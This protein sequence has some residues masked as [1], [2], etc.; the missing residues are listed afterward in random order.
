MR[1][2]ARKHGWV[3]LAL[4]G[5]LVVLVGLLWRA[6][7]DVLSRTKVH[8]DGTPSSRHRA[9][10]PE[11]TG[12][13]VPTE[14]AGRLPDETPGAAVGESLSLDVP[15]LSP[16]MLAPNEQ[17]HAFSL[18]IDEY[19]KWLSVRTVTADIKV[20]TAFLDPQGAFSP[21]DDGTLT[22]KLK[23]EVIPL[24]KK[25]FDSRMKLRARVEVE[26]LGIVILTENAYDTSTPPLVWSRTGEQPTEDEAL[27][28]HRDVFPDGA[29]PWESMFRMVD[30]AYDGFREWE[31]T[32]IKTLNELE[33]SSWW[34]PVRASTAQEEQTY[35]EGHRQYLFHLSPE[36]MNR[37]WFDAER[38]ETTMLETPDPTL[39]GTIEHRICFGQYVTEENGDAHFPTTITSEIRRQ[40]DNRVWRTEAT[41]SNVKLNEAIPSADFTAPPGA[42]PMNR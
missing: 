16:S 4:A 21:G 19:R 31:D 20:R 6:N 27:S 34:I 40:E 1:I 32:G 25:Q 22:A 11:Q 17:E 10:E 30:S 41:L 42:M 37:F 15:L 36:H 35:F 26:E 33:P 5:L 13:R 7:S 28:Y 12:I 2:L 9:E 8:G 29:I 18:M 39:P 3:P 24:E 23:L 14:D 38:G